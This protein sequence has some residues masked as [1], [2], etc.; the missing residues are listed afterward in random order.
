MDVLTG[1][2]DADGTARGR[3]MGVAVDAA[4][5]LLFSDDVGNKIW[6][7]TPAAAAVR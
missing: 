7:V 4:G 3:P 6:R 1:F 5:A 2:L